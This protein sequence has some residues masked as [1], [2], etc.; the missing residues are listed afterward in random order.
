M[1]TEL[2]LPRMVYM[3]ADY[4]IIV[5]TPKLAVLFRNIGTSHEAWVLWQTYLIAFASECD[6]QPDTSRYIRG[7]G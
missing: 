5:T 1:Y 3:Y 6:K 7:S 2:T 4:S